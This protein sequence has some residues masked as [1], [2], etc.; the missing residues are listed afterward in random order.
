MVPYEIWD[1]VIFTLPI[2]REEFHK[3]RRAKKLSQLCCLIIANRETV[4]GST[5]LLGDHQKLCAHTKRDSSRARTSA[6]P[7]HYMI[8]I[9]PNHTLKKPVK[10][11][12]RSFPLYQNYV[13]NVYFTQLSKK[14]QDR[15]IIRKCNLKY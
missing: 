15:I 13:Y 11:F 4:L 14:N 5:T 2:R 12:A 1:H 8:N 6:Q 7:R 10:I 3:N 9:L